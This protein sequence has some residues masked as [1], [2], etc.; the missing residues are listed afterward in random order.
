MSQKNL[1]YNSIFYVFLFLF[2][3]F[4]SPPNKKIKLFGFALSSKL[5]KKRR[6]F[7]HM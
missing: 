5:A 3:F 7:G 4:T 2:Y 6:A 1:P